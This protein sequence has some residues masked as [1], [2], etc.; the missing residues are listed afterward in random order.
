MYRL[1]YPRSSNHDG[2]FWACLLKLKDI[3][4]LYYSGPLPIPKEPQIRNAFGISE[5]T[6]STYDSL[7]T[8]I[9]NLND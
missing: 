1:Y 3:K 8:N 4:G 2:I 7:R 9:K 5:L 6:A